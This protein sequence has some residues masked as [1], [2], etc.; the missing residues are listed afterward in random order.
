MSS[1]RRARL[2]SP[3]SLALFLSVCTVGGAVLA[4]D[5]RP[6]SADEPSAVLD[7]LER[8]ADEASAHGPPPAALAPAGHPHQLPQSLAP[9]LETIQPA[10]VSIRSMGAERPFGL[11][12]SQGIGSGFILDPSGVVVTNHHVVDHASRLEVHLDDGR[13][14][15]GRVLGSDPQTDLAVVKLEGARNLPTVRLGDSESTKVGDWVIA[16]GSPMG[17]AQTVSTGIVSGKGRG[18]LGLYRDSYIDFLQ[19]DAAISPGSSGGPLFDMKGRVIGVNTAVAGGGRGLGFA[20]PAAQLKVVVPQLRAHGKMERGWLG[21]SGKDEQPELGE[22]PIPG[23]DVLE[24]YE[25]TPAAKGGLE[26]GDRILAVDGESVENFSDLRGRI[27]DRRAGTRVTLDV[28]RGGKKIKVRVELESLPGD[29]ARARLSPAR[30][31]AGKIPTAPGAGLYDGK[32][33]LG[34]KVTPEAGGLR[35]VEVTKGSV[36]EK[37]GLRAGDLIEDV[38]G[39]EVSS[40]DDVATALMSDEH[41]VSVVVDRNGAKHTARLERR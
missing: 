27:G 34:V 25:E 26:K 2:R 4:L 29:P 16:I 17:L 18:D 13:R 37:L 6:A 24:V 11:G 23:A 15:E 9:L 14:F 5:S 20:V 38:N 33:R 21:I 32:P 12:Q 10:V 3:L 28:D 30:P 41:A 35:V 40:V 22:F 8:L 31:G 36:G 1:F 7:P 39:N 19:T